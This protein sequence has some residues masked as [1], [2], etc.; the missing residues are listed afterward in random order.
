MASD[1]RNAPKATWLT[2]MARL[3]PNVPL[4]EAQAALD[5]LVREI[6][7]TDSHIVVEPAG[8][9]VPGLEQQFESP[10]LVLMAA[11][12]LVLLIACSNLA[13]LL[14]GRATARTHEIGVRL[15]LGA[16]R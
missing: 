2:V 4:R 1:W 9:G 15:A 16:R 11:V 10:L 12:G 7:A 6:R 5:R 8:R 3:R 13:T 14:L